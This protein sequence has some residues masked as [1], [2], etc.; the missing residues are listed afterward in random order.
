M[1]DAN[2]ARFESDRGFLYYVNCLS[3]MMTTTMYWVGCVW[4]C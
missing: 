4:F 2:M 1:S 3:L